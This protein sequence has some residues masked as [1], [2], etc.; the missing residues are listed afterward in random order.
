MTRV[1][2]PDDFS[3][4]GNVTLAYLKANYTTTSTLNAELGS[5][6][7]E[8]KG[9]ATGLTVSDFK[10]TNPTVI[11]GSTVS[12][13][14]LLV[15]ST[16]DNLQLLQVANSSDV[17]FEI[18]SLG[19]VSQ[20]YTVISN[21]TAT[22]PLL[23]IQTSDDSANHKLLE[24]RDLNDEILFDVDKDGN[25]EC[26]GGSFGAVT[27]VSIAVGGGTA[28]GT[29]SQQTEV[30]GG[31]FIGD[32]QGPPN[33]FTLSVNSENITTLGTVAFVA[34]TLTWTSKG[35]AVSTDPVRINFAYEGK[36]NWTITS[37]TNVTFTGQLG[38]MVTGAGTTAA[39]ITTIQ[40][41][42]SPVN[43]LVSQCGA[44]GSITFT[45]MVNLS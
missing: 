21:G 42:G 34:V 33:N 31:F 27:A 45:G 2:N 29:Y 4:V 12:G 23:K 11:Q 41:G 17:Q 43:L 37:A 16:D 14:L 3:S 36:A 40:S 15:E 22:A 26:N 19:H 39:F 20:S 6:V 5:K 44:T 38:G 9:S 25:M 1:F 28:L 8:V 32:N 35:S 10:A 13:P 30:T 7:D 18:N 24:M